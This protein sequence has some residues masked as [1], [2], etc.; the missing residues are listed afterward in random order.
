MYTNIIINMYNLFS[1]SKVGT[2]N[3]LNIPGKFVK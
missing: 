1:K 3:H 2:Q